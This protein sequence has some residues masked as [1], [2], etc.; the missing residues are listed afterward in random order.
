MKKIAL[1]GLAGALA[2]LLAQGPYIARADDHDG[3]DHDGYHSYGI[4]RG[5]MD[6]DGYHGYDMN[7]GRRDF[8]GYHGYNMDDGRRDSDRHRGYDMG[9]M[10]PGMMHDGGLRDYGMGPD[11][12]GRG[13]ENEWNFH[14]HQS[15]ENRKE[16][17]RI[18]QDYINS[19]HNPDLKLGKIKDEGSEFEAD[20]MNR[21]H[22]LVGKLFVDKDTGRLQRSND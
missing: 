20:L 14:R 22:F 7:D 8:E 4:Y 13:Y 11:M 18:F 3:T 17:A 2:I 9:D 12:M 5:G 21:D 6:S 1:W 16:A 15:I 19:R 10:G